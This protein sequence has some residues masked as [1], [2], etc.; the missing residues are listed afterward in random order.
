MKGA[1]DAYVRTAARI[2][3]NCQRLAAHPARAQWQNGPDFF[4][5]ERLLEQLEFH[6]LERGTL[7]TSLLG[8][9]RGTL[10]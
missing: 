8:C 2:C 3:E 1:E 6:L 9:E 5:E 7:R 10:L 4:G